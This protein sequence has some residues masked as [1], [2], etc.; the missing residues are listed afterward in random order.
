VAPLL[1]LFVLVV[2]SES[3][4]ARV[5]AERATKAFEAGRH[6]EALEAGRRAYALDPKPSLLN[7]LGVVLEALGRFDEA[8]DA[9]RR[10][11]EDPNASE[12]LR[13]TDQERLAALKPRLESAVV[14]FEDVGIGVE[15]TVGGAR[16][17]RRGD[18][19]AA[20]GPAVLSLRTGTTRD[21]V[22][23]FLDLPLGRR[24]T[25]RPADHQGRA[26]DGIIDVGA[27]RL[28]GVTIDGFVLAWVPDPGTLIKLAP[29]AHR[30]EVTTREG[31]RITHAVEL[32]SGQT[33][34]LA[35][36]AVAPAPP[37]TSEQP[38][39]VA[40]WIVAAGGVVVAIAGGVLLGVAHADAGALEPMGGPVSFGYPEAL[41]RQEAVDRKAGVGVGLMIGGG[42]AVAAG[43]LWGLLT[44]E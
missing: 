34:S 8:A 3:P 23:R 14:R 41:E 39:P 6:E 20:P 9:F 38:T 43:A 1:T 19:L 12:R 27:A 44:L 29:G 22:V 42:V 5:W 30:I 40:P 15:A 4:E 26:T 10:V 28:R 24:T 37:P 2:G 35:P 7:N 31:D 11:I 32:V 33:F 21:L 13:T 17:D 36:E 18:Q 25:I 16:S